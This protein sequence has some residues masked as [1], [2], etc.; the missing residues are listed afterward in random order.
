MFLLKYW[1][2]LLGFS[3]CHPTWILA[4][5]ID[6]NKEPASAHEDINDRTRADKYRLTSR[7]V[8]KPFLLIYKLGKRMHILMI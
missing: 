5:F 1:L 6:E 4:K 8:L 3:L 7:F 2:L